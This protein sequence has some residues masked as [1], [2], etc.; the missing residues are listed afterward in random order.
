MPSYDTPAVDPTTLR[1]YPE[2]MPTTYPDT[3]AVNAL[4]ATALAGLSGT[5]LT[6]ALA[7]TPVEHRAVGGVYSGRPVTDR[8]VWWMT[9]S[10]LP[11]ASGSTTSGTGPVVDLD[12]IFLAPGVGALT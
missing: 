9:A 8:P 5:S 3:T 7:S 6:A 11:P 10:V 12:S 2:F 1:I 4:I